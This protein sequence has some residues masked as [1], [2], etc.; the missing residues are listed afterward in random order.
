ML[1]EIYLCHTSS[2]HEIEDGNARVGTMGPADV[3]YGSGGAS[4]GGFGGVYGMHCYAAPR[5]AEAANWQ[6][7]MPTSWPTS[8]G[9]VPGLSASSSEVAAAAAAGKSGK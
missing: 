2:C 5:H 8:R 3:D 1:T 4:G 7:G 9:Y 6:E